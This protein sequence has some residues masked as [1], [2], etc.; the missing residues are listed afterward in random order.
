MQYSDIPLLK[1]WQGDTY[2]LRS[3]DASPQLKALD[4]DIEKY[5][6][7]YS[8]M[9]RRNLL[10]DM[11]VKF[12]A[13][14]IANVAQTRHF[15]SAALKEILGKKKAG[16]A[17]DHTYSHAVCIA[18]AVACSTNAG[19]YYHTSIDDRTDM[20]A[21]C[22]D[23]K[24]A[25]NS[26][27]ANFPN[28]I[29]DNENTLKIFMAPEFYF[30]GRNGAYSPDIVADIIPTMM[31]E[32][33]GYKGTGHGDFKH[34]LFVFGTAVSALETRV[35]FCQQCQSISAV[36]YVK[37][38][39]GK[40]ITECKNDPTHTIASGSYGAE[41]HNVA[42][43]Q[44]NKE[45]YLVTKEYTSGI[46]YKGVSVATPRGKVRL[47]PGT[48][49]VKLMKVIPPH[50][51]T[52]LLYCILFLYPGA[53]DCRFIFFDKLFGF[54]PP[55]GSAESQIQSKFDDERMGGSVFTIDG[56]T[57]GL[58]ICLDHIASATPNQGRLAEYSDSIQIHLIPSYG[59]SI[60]N[61]MYCKANGI[62][63]NVDGRPNVPA[64]VE[65]KGVG[66]SASVPVN[67]GT[68]GNLQ[69]FGPFQIPA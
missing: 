4:A 36:K 56:I 39:D 23:M 27:L 29:A 58:E 1:T 62:V 12:H 20:E 67:S 13:W 7:A 17:P 45:R 68:R 32:E 38:P 5:N 33:G 31:K 66:A 15:A 49:D 40:T 63:F 22:L 25:I 34:W 48:P 28:A 19:D 50:G 44:K 53:E 46:D 43:I 42:L 14:E 47:H 55:Q 30:R 8:D 37:Q 9:A 41:V 52:F 57:F 6:Q 35:T 2:S 21:K 54:I 51:D 3:P 11:D 10:N 65:I 69:F 59:M 16:I 18:W 26:A 24:R 64:E 60:G 61:K